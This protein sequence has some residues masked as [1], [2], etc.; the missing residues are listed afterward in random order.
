M[1][2][3][4]MPTDGR[5]DGPDCLLYLKSAVSCNRNYSTR[6][7]DGHGVMFWGRNCGLMWQGFICTPE[8]SDNGQVTADRT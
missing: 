5:T 7:T 6:G 1:A 8:N 4:P 2:P 3:V